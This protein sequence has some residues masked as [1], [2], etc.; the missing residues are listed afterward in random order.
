MS[1]PVAIIFGAGSNVGQAVAKAF[2]AKGYKVA[3]LARR[4]QEGDES[5]GQLRINADLTDPDS[6]VQAF[7]RVK[8]KL[9]IPSVVVYNGRQSNPHISSC[10]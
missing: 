3:I 5:D 1:A 9:G 8:S 2:T 4:L 6:V 7:S 10:R